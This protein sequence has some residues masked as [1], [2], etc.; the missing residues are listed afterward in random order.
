[1]E[2]AGFSSL[3]RLDWLHCACGSIQPCR[4]RETPRFIAAWFGWPFDADALETCLDRVAL[5]LDRG[6]DREAG[7][8]VGPGGQ[9]W[10]VLALKTRP[11]AAVWR[12]RSG[13]YPLHVLAGDRGWSIAPRI[14]TLEAMT[15]RRF[16]LNRRGL[17]AV[18]Q[19][20][21][22]AVRIP[23]YHGP[24]LVEP[25]V[26]TVLQR[27]AGSRRVMMPSCGVDSGDPDGPG[28]AAEEARARL[29]GRISETLARAVP[30]Q[31]AVL[32]LSGGLDSNLLLHAA[33]AAGLVVQ[34]VS[35][36]FP[37]LDCDEQAAIEPSCQRA[38]MAPV[39]VDLR[40]ASFEAWRERLFEAAEYVPFPSTFI[41]L[42]LSGHARRAGFRVVLD[43]TGG[44][45]VFW[46]WRRRAQRY[47]IRTGAWRR[48]RGRVRPGEWPRL[49]AGLTRALLR[50]PPVSN[51]MW[52]MAGAQILG[53]IGIGMRSPFRDASLARAI[54]PLA[55]LDALTTGRSRGLQRDLLETLCPGICDH[56][57]V[58]KVNFNAVAGCIG[59]HPAGAGA[60]R[61]AEFGRAGSRLWSGLVPA[62]VDYKRRGGVEVL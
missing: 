56:V 45:E 21:A 18:H 30:R 16:A 60:A 14:R 28:A 54:A 41:A 13:V 38:G 2:A 39:L 31:G 51:A 26:F 11:R 58:R 52:Y 59:Q 35:A 61:H 17:A 5:W 4:R 25:G 53:E 36:V 20:R 1:M 9:F 10:C 23:L 15:R 12:D 27:G 42:A 22:G 24:A 29:P 49:L 48:L 44:D 57:G 62:F 7:A 19:G 34:P 6:D 47:L 8:P 32:R 33:A 43:G 50:A 46:F 37:G 3:I 40:G 55:A